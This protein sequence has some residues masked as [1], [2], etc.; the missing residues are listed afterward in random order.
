MTV[1]KQITRPTSYA[2]CDDFRQVFD[3]DMN[4]LYQLAFLLTADHEKAEQCFVAGLDDAIKGNPVFKEWARSWARRM[5]SLNAVRVINPRPAEG[6]GRGRSRSDLADRNGMAPSDGQEAEI[7]AILEL[8]PF[9]RFVYLMTVLERYSDQ[10]CSVLLGC[11][12]RDVLA[13]RT[14]AFQEVGS[15]METYYKRLPWASPK[16]PA[17]RGRRD[18]ALQLSATPRWATSS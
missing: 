4:T 11:T 3:E 7:A 14:R 18:S 15:T 2:R 17:L 8:K 1:A 16:N 13:A 12:R 10:E 6:N 9:E 5:V